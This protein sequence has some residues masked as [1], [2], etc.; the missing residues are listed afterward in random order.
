MKMSNK[1][2]PS[3]ASVPRI[4]G[5]GSRHVAKASGLLFLALAGC[6]TGPKVVRVPVAVSCAPDTLPAEPERISDKL[7][8]NAERDIGIVAASNIRL[9]SWG[10]ELRAI[11]TGCQNSEQSNQNQGQ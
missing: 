7:T 8:G 1:A 10:N 3:G 5:G 9:R 4:F 2:G 11:L 6:A